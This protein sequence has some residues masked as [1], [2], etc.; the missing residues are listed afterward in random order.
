MCLTMQQPYDVD[1]DDDINRNLIF[2]HACS[3]I[4]NWCCRQWRWRRQ[5]RQHY[6]Y[7][8][9][10]A[11]L[12]EPHSL[13]VFHRVIYYIISERHNGNT[14]ATVNDV[15]AVICWWQYA[16]IV[17]MQVLFVWIKWDPLS[18]C[19]RYRCSLQMATTTSADR[20]PYFYLSRFFFIHQIMICTIRF[21]DLE[22][23]I[24]HKF[25]NRPRSISDSI[26]IIITIRPFFS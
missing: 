1:D 6:R 22:K 21:E 12:I 24:S 2:S 11:P 20:R 15:R 25:I 16:C 9:W 26:P 4:T 5:R 17:R 7:C 19:N 3:W 13:Q 23:K 8:L 14:K 10:C 18:H